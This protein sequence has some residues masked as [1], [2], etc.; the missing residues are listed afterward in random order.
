MI[1]NT[2]VILPCLCEHEFQDAPYGKGMRV[3]NVNEK[4]DAYCTVCSPSYS[5]DKNAVDV[6]RSDVFGMVMMA[7]ARRARYPKK[8]PENTPVLPPVKA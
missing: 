2:T 3:H 4:G 7:P 8:I 5:R 6:P 1:K